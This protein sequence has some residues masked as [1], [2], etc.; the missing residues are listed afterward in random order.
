MT[1]AVVLAG[2]Q[3]RRMGGGD[4]T[5]LQ[6]DGVSLLDRILLALRPSPVAISANGDPGRFSAYRVP[7]LADGP[8]Q[9]QGPLAGILA[10]LDWA[11]SQNADAL[12]TVPGDTPLIPCDLAH[13]LSPAPACAASRG[14][15]HHLVAL[16]PTSARDALRAWL[17]APGPRDVA[18]F[19]ATLGPRIIDFPAEAWDPFTNVNTPMDLERLANPDGG[20]GR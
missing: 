11:I 16:W 17:T 12:L 10:G 2:G 3:A 15:V 8:F 19:A 7:V 20:K 1:V 14:R 4:K 5:L 18:G 9:D 6:L 13:T